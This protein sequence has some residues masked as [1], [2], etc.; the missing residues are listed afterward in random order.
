MPRPR[1][2]RTLLEEEEFEKYLSTYF[3]AHHIHVMDVDVFEE[4]W[5]EHL[6]N[7]LF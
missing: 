7:L 6:D 5:V 3:S 2:Q 1:S 4:E